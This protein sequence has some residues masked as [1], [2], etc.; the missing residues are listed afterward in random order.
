MIETRNLTKIYRSGFFLKKKIG[1]QNLSLKVESG[2]VFGFLGQNGAG[3]TTTIKILVGLSHPTSGEA[4]VLG[5]NVQNREVRRNIGFVPEA[6]YFYEYLTAQEAM[7]FYAQIYALPR[8]VWKQR[9][10]E[11]LELVELT[12]SAKRQI[13]HYSKGMRQRLGLA[14]ALLP[15]PAVVIMDEPTSGLDPLGR[16]LVKEIILKLKEQRKT[17]FFSSHILPDVEAICNRVGLIH[18]GQLLREGSVEDLVGAEPAKIEIICRK[19]SPESLSPFADHLFS[20]GELLY[21]WVSSTEKKKQ[22]IEKIHQLGGEV[23]YIIPHRHSLEEYFKNLTKK[24]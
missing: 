5:Q 6:P 1:I 15:D 12:E 19:V 11:L 17:V 2:E 20:E 24:K 8:S 4:L 3:K 16:R 18:K 7:Q 23:E 9:I 22:I 10:P 13:R 14:Q 21:L